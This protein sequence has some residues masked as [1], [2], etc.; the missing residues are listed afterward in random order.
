MEASNGTLLAAK[1]S[2]RKSMRRVVFVLLRLAVGIGIVVYLVKSGRLEP[3][4]LTR[5]LR[6][7]PLTL[8]GMMVLLID[9]L[10]MSV[11]VSLLF[12]AQHL[13]L[14]LRNA[15]QLTL[16]G[17]FFSTFL[18]GA[19]GGDLAKL[20]Y[21]TREN[22]GR[23][24]EIATV[25]FFDRIMGLL[26][27]VLIP[28]FV[29]PLFV[30][31][32]QAEPL[33]RWILRM[34]ALVGVGL[35][36][37]IALVMFSAPFRRGFSRMLGRWRG[38]RIIAERVLEAMAVFGK[39]RGLLAL[40]LALSFLA[41]LALVAVTALG[42]Y[43]VNPGALSLRLCLVAP[44]GHLINSLPLTPGGL[45]IGETAFNALFALTD[46]AGG[47]DTLFCVRIW[48]LLV[49]ALGLLNYMFGMARIVHWQ[50]DHPGTDQVASTKASSAIKKEVD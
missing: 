22:E 16:I 32:L 20:F 6:E 23:R 14:R 12:H 49:G 13:S 28:L 30:E 40:T 5:G 48:S 8:M 41:N 43:T 11:R 45:G 21:A 4:S 9:I 25:L 17:F 19:A 1:E 42:L 36:L 39:A 24:T 47:A 44:I 15:I 37:G 46:M 7:W 33:L 18:P 3:H 2:H 31:L 34:D 10:F 26:A 50:K 27:L 38:P 29:A 35:C